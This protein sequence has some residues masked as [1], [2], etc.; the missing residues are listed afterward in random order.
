MDRKNGES[1]SLNKLKQYSLRK[2][3]PEILKNG[4]LI[5]AYEALKILFALLF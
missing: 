5:F 4:Q 1:G 2:E 3:I